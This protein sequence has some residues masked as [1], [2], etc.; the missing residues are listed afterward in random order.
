MESKPV[1]AANQK[2]IFDAVKEAEMV[3]ERI[4]SR[5]PI[6][7]LWLPSP[8]SPPPPN[9]L[10]IVQVLHDLE[11]IPPRILWRELLLSSVTSAYYSLS[12]SGARTNDFLTNIRALMRAPPVA[13][14]GRAAGLRHVST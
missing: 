9:N 3:P 14:S 6:L 8:L 1:S 4:F 13:C 11:N 7:L 5:W 10:P 2:P 12:I